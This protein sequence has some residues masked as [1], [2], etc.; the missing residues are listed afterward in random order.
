M[1][2]LSLFPLIFAIIIE[3]LVIAIRDHSDIHG[4]QCGRQTHK[5][6][7]FADDI[8]LFVTDP[9][10][11]LPNICKLLDN[12]SADTGLKVNYSKSTALNVNIP[13]H[14]VSR[15]KEKFRFQWHDSC[16]PYLG[17]NLAASVDRFYEINFSPMYRKLA[18]DLVHWGKLGLSWLG[19]VNSIK[20]NLLPRILYLF[21]AL[22]I[23]IRRDQLRKFQSKILRFI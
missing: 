6:A 2:G 23:P 7:L 9:L 8:L 22:P 12:F 10:I 17:V 11:S 3:T 19:R 18:E 16:I 4:L 1:A 21:R 13:E 5:C 15:L 14:L 20:M